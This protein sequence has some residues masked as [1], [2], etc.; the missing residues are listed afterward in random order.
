MKKRILKLFLLLVLIILPY[1]VSAYNECN[2]NDTV[3]LNK[4][5]NNILA[6]YSYY[7]VNGNLKFKIT[8]NNLNSNVYIQDVRKKQTYY[9]TGEITLENYG[10]NQTIE[11]RIYSNLAY[12]KGYYLNSLYVTLPPYNPYHK[13]KLCEGIESYRLCQRW[14]N[15]S[16]TYDEFKKEINNYLN[17]NKKDNPID[18]N[19]YKSIY[20]IILDFYIKYY[21]IILP[22][23]IVV[24]GIIILVKRRNETI[25]D[26]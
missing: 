19:D 13:D 6:N 15:V 24:G 3:R 17:S 8:I 4:I 1:K 12:C 23:I 7:E 20:Q 2:N 25:D 18:L 5:A 26:F 22:I 10:P 21:Y 16:L 11:Y 14:T 9:S